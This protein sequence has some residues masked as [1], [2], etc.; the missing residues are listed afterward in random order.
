MHNELDPI[1]DQWYQHRDKG[2]LIR[3]VAIEQPGGVIE[4]QDF[5]GSIEAIDLEAWRDMELDVAE[6]PED[7]TGPYDDIEIDDLGYSSDTNMS[8]R[9]WRSPLDSPQ[10][11]DE[12]WQDGRSDDSATNEVHWK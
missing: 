9:D 10:A 12:R 3:V 6:A 2:G 4:V 5:D 1:V 8:Q 7:W 11:D